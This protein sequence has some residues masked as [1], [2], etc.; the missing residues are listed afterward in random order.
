MHEAVSDFTLESAIDGPR[1]LAGLLERISEICEA[2]AEHVAVNWQDEK[3]AK[4]WTKAAR[5]VDRAAL[6][7]AVQGV[8]R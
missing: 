1:G 5:A 8:S 7:K 3:T 4:A 6:S 2:K